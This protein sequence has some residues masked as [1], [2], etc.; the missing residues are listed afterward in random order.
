MPFDFVMFLL[1]KG[2]KSVHLVSSNF[3]HQEFT[4]TRELPEISQ[5]HPPKCTQLAPDQVF[6]I[7]SVNSGLK[8][9]PCV[10]KEFVSEGSSNL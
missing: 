5:V 10:P 4:I 1:F 2:K 6:T 7:I 3:S 9:Y 8:Q